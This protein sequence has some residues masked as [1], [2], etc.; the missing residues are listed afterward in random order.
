[1]L[2]IFSVLNAA[3]VRRFEVEGVAMVEYN[4]LTIINLLLKLLGPL[5][6]RDLTLLLLVLQAGAG[7]L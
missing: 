5:H 4:N 7:V 2:A 6:E 1:M 3:H